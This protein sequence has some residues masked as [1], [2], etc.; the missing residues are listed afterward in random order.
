MSA[1][2]ALDLEATSASPEEAKIL[3]IA[4][5]DAEDRTFHRYVATP[6]ALEADHPAFR[7]T[8]IPFE[9]Y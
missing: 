6:E 9:E 5:Q 3:E 4:A 7:F 8:G 1:Y 2:V